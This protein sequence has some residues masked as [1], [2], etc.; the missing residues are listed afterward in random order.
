LSAKTIPIGLANRSISE[1]PTSLPVKHL[2]NS[3]RLALYALAYGGSAALQKG[4]GFVLFMWLAHSLSVQAYA[5]FGLLYALQAGLATLAVAGVI[6]AVV[7]LLK[8]HRTDGSRATLFGTANAVFVVLS[9]VCVTIVVAG[10]G[11]LTR[12]V[13]ASPGDL[14]LVVVAGVLT[15]FFTM[16]SQLVRLEENHRSS[17]ALNF[18]PPV[19]GLLGGCI[20]FFY[21]RTLSGFFA[22]L[23]IGLVLL[24]LT[25]KLLRVGV[26][27]F[28]RHPRDTLPI[29]AR[30]APF[31]LIA[32]LGWLSGYGNTYL[33]KSFFTASDVARFT[34]VYTLSSIMQLVATALNQ[35]WSPRI[36]KL[37]HELPIEQVESRNRQFFRLQGVALGAVGA[38][39]LILAPVAIQFG[40][41]SL[42]AYRGLTTEL[43]FLSAAYALSIP[44]YHVQN[45]YYAHSKGKELMN[46]TLGTSIVGMLLWLLS[47]WVFGALGVYIGF[48]TML[49]TRMLGALVWAR[50]EWAIDIAWEGTA[51]AMVLLLGGAWAAHSVSRL[52]F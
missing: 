29:F 43:F 13:D 37:V 6:E 7:G 19:A 49:T 24:L 3:N 12:N 28:V 4:L 11:L 51:I 32:L 16:Q 38:A 35:V 50:R 14:A 9:L 21:G 39:V 31:I 45:F 34:F 52:A 17:L 2:L 44:W 33:V 40:G 47:M 22:G 27:G 18:F 23:A 25:F 46:I 41:A 30:I 20:G 5:S 42:A 1:E 10:S 15:A 48:M 36:F 8:E 26:Y